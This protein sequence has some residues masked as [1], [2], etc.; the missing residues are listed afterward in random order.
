MIF[1]SNFFCYYLFPS[2]SNSTFVSCSL[3]FVLGCL[4]GSQRRAGGRKRHVARGCPPADFSAVVGKWWVFGNRAAF[5]LIGGPWHSPPAP[6]R[7]SNLA[8][9]R[10]GGVGTQAVRQP[11]RS[12]LPPVWA[13]CVSVALGWGR[14]RRESSVSLQRS[15]V[16]HLLC[17][18]IS[19]P[20][21]LISFLVP[22]TTSSQLASA[23]AARSLI[24]PS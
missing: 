24:F 17:P 1:P 9:Q 7:G 19:A 6:C 8:G 5:P 13:L 15:W 3:N 4:P 22:A 23:E 18:R 11:G 20:P 21:F 12:V 14:G 2:D 10:A 16:I